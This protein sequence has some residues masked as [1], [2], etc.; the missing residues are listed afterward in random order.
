MNEDLA[1]W[2]Q[3]ALTAADYNFH[4][5]GLNEPWLKYA[6][7]VFDYQV[8]QWM[9]PR[10]SRNGGIPSTWAPLGASWSTWSSMYTGKSG[11]SYA[12]GS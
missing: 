11:Q 2:A 7:N 12:F 8:Q 1:L 10:I 9:T 4:P 3:L 5:E 6:E